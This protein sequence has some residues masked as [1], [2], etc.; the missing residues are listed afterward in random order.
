MFLNEIAFIAFQKIKTQTPE[1]WTELN[2][3]VCNSIAFFW[4][5][6]ITELRAIK[7]TFAQVKSTCV[8]NPILTL[9]ATYK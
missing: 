6:I 3:I 1:N 5:A 9:S 8:G 7:F 2:A 4:S